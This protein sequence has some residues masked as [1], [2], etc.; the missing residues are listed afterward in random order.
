MSADLQGFIFFRTT[1]R[2][3]VSVRDHLDQAE[4]TDWLV[5]DFRQVGGLDWAAVNSFHK[6]LQ[7]ARRQ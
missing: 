6:L 3:V 1:N 4:Q 2:I 7:L 5:L